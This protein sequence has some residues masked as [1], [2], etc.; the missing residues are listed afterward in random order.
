MSKPIDYNPHL[1]YKDDVIRENMGLV[2]HI[3]N[4]FR[5]RV[6]QG[7]GYDDLAS[8]GSIGLLKAFEY[9]D[10]TKVEGGI[11]FATYAARMIQGY[12]QNYLNSKGSSVKTPASILKVMRVI[13]KENL[14]CA[15][16]SE[17]VE[18]TGLTLAEANSGLLFLENQQV[19]SLDVQLSEDMESS[20]LLSMIPSTDDSTHMFVS[21]FI[22]SLKD[23]E[24]LLIKMLMAGT[25]QHVI[26]EELGISQSYISKLTLRIGKKYKK[27]LG[28]PEREGIKMSNEVKNR[29][30]NVEEA[31][32]LGVKTVLDEIEWYVG[33]ASSGVASISLNSLGM[34]ISRLAAETLE[35]KVGD[36][37][38]VGF[39]AGLMRLVIRKGDVGTK[40]NKSTG[41]QGSVA[42]NNKA[43]GRW[44]LGKNIVRRRYA[45]QFDETSQVHFIQLEAAGRE[46]GTA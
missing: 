20:S 14:F 15:S 5:V 1:G 34:H 9:F 25:K 17:I 12:I 7:V 33:E 45:L 35:L 10:P 32:R 19:A 8:E 22:E 27:Y 29:K 4:K 21:E 38:Q 43:I 28:I 44:I 18:K 13:H 3:A 16:A 30:I 31:K 6:N 46:V 23:R 2:H 26:A 41:T 36:F 11:K 40:L 37:I 24:Q 39:N 42:T